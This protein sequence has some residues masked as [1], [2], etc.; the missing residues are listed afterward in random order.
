MAAKQKGSNP[1]EAFAI[2]TFNIKRGIIGGISLACLLL[3]GLLYVASPDPNNVVLATTLRVGIVLFA[4]W[5][6]MPQMR[7]VLAK[8]PAVLPIASLV[9][10]LLCAARPNLFRLVGSLIVIAT[11]LFGI[12]KW[13]KTVSKP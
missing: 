3:A 1:D 7:D 6:A 9:L 5:L 10:V 4:I 13:I 11:A 8:L 2:R 12:S